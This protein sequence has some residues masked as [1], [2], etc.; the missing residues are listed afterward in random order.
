[1]W[2]TLATCAC[3]RACC[4]RRWNKRAALLLAPPQTLARACTRT[5]L[6]T[7]T[8]LSRS[9]APARALARVHAA[10]ARVRNCLCLRRRK[11]MRL[12][13]SRKLGRD[14]SLGIARAA[15]AAPVA[16]ETTQQTTDRPS[17]IFVRVISTI[18]HRLPAQSMHWFSYIPIP[19][20]HKS[21]DLHTLGYS[22]V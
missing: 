18:L 4:A 15:D 13:A 21:R 20:K 10:R 2:C 17:F 22:N 5:S 14:L 12:V 8:T 9:H 6:G 19:H 1:M 16:A 3:S 11:Q 7:C